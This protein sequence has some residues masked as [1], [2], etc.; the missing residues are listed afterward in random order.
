[1]TEASYNDIAE[2]YDHFLQERPVYSEVILP[3]L[4]ELVGSFR[5]SIFVT[6]HAD[7]AGLHANW[8]G[9]GRR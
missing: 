7:R 4:L 6:W 3:N 2:W 9:V 1:M 8:R 5:E